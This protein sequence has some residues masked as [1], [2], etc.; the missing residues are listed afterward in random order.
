MKLAPASGAGAA[1]RTVAG[2]GKANRAWHAIARVARRKVDGRDQAE[3]AGTLGR[4]PEEEA[5]TP[6]LGMEYG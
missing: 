5:R 6:T 4:G 1:E 3:R 2:L